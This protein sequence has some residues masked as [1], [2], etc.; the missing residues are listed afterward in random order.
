MKDEDFFSRN[1]IDW[2]GSVKF[3]GG[4]AGP[5][6]I[7]SQRTADVRTTGTYQNPPERGKRKKAN[8]E[9]RVVDDESSSRTHGDGSYRRGGIRG[10]HSV[11]LFTFHE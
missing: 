6:K 2:K 10:T 3:A 9:H 8:E 7:N 4:R 5:T 11:C 1:L